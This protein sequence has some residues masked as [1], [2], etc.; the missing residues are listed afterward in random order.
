MTVDSLRRLLAPESVAVI[1]ASR[2]RGMVGRAILDNV[3]DAGYPGRVY[4]VNPRAR[5]VNG[6]HCLAS[7]AELPSDVDLAVIAVPAEVVPGVAEQCGQRGVGA[8]IVITTGLGIAAEA[9]LLATC[10]RHGMRLVGP[11]SFGVAVPSIGL[12]ATGTARHPVPGTVGLAAQPGDMGLAVAGRLSR[13]G[14]GI[15]SFAAVGDKLDVSC[16]DL[17]GWWEQDG[18]TRLAVLCTESFGNPRKFARTVR[19]AG[20]RMPVLAVQSGYQA[21]VAG[22]Q[23]LFRQAGVVVVPGVGEL[24]E[25]VALIAT[26]PLPAGKTVAIVTNAGSAGRVAADACAR[27]G[28]TLYEPRGLT[29]RRLHALIPETGAVDGL[30]DTTAAVPADR[31]RRVLELVAA[32]EDVHAVIALALPTAATGD[33]VTVI[34]QAPMPVPLTAVLLD[35]DEQVRL[36]PGSDGR[37]RVPAYADPAGAAAAVARAAAYGAWRARQRGAAP[38]FGDIETEHARTVIQR[39]LRHAPDGGWLPADRVASLL[40]YYGIAITPPEC[41]PGTELTIQITV[42]DVFGPVIVSEP[43]G[44]GAT[45]ACPV[46]L[47]PLTAADADKV[48]QSEW[49]AVVPRGAQDG[50]VRD[51][52]AVREL[53]LR[54]GQL[55][56]D[57]P[58]ITD[59][60]LGGIHTGP[61]GAFVADACVR[62]AGR[63]GKDAFLQGLSGRPAYGLLQRQLHQREGACSAKVRL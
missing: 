39:F 9:D 10:R 55:A 52:V 43:G 18:R 40:S 47:A 22:R 45:A 49:T 50:A 41:E 35:Q 19:R 59:L 2:R 63:H 25:T 12:D 28:L 16:N 14:I 3:R 17:L 42:D 27:N 5:Q 21:A 37:E 1:G 15:S 7:A 58:E 26:Q 33:L 23:D 54:A 48:I 60:R 13:L 56:Y 30:I 32:D 36:L 24:A 62:A 38:R 61:D 46:R 34:R 8:L 29:R 4:A 31:F 57:L 11:G 51:L 53:L 6:E 44:A 20:A